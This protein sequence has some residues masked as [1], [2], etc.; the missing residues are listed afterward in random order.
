M[1]PRISRR[2]FLHLSALATAGGVLA[3]CGPKAPAPAPEV[4]AT[5]VP[6][7]EAPAT[8]ATAP[9]PAEEPPTA[10][11]SGFGEAP[12]LAE[13]VAA[14]ELPPVEDRLPLEPKLVNEFPPSELELEIGQY[15]GEIRFGTTDP[16]LD[17]EL[18]CACNE[19]LV[20]ISGII[21]QDVTPNVVKD[22]EVSDD[23]MQFTFY[24][25]EGLKWSDGEPVTTEDVRF[26]FEDVL[27][28][29]E[30]TSGLP[31][32]LRAANQPG[33]EPF[34]YEIID[35]FT[36]RMS[37]AKPYGGFLAQLAVAGWRGY[38]EIIKPAHYL[39]QFH[40]KHA[41]A[42]EL[43]ALVEQAGVDTWVQL[44]SMKD[45]TGV[46]GIY[47]TEAIGFPSLQP[48]L[49]A[50]ESQDRKAFLRNPYY[51]KVDAA[52]QQLPYIDRISS[53]IFSN[54]ESFSLAQIAGEIDCS[55]RFTS[56]TK[57]AL[58]KEN[59]EV[60]G[61][62]ARLVTDHTNGSLVHL[63]LTYDDPAWLQ[64][65]QDL[66]FRQA[67]NMAIDREEIIDAIYLGYG[68]LPTIVPSEFDPDKANQLLDE[69]GLDQRDNE[70]YRLGFDGKTFEIPFEISNSDANFAL[71]AELV[72]ENWGR[73]GLKTS[74]KVIEAN[75]WSQRNGA[76]ELQATVY[77]A[78]LALWFQ[79]NRGQD[80]SAPLWTLWWNTRGEEGE[81]PPEEFQA[82]LRA[83]GDR[84]TVPMEEAAS[85]IEQERRNVHDNIWFM[86]I[87]EN[88][89]EA[90]IT[91]AR[92]G[93]VPES[94]DLIGIVIDFSA[95][96][97]FVKD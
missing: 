20:N 12:M 15:G 11:E 21:H 60:G 1:R 57:M 32:W 80:V 38:Q 63:N 90:M 85:V 28:N 36:F 17:A 2:S 6:E 35:D 92:Y 95:E 16:T 40:P 45:V 93:N 37:F 73:I 94:E 51:F 31:A 46:A 19:P 91:N 5:D 62:K 96:Q 52:G 44:F 41:D 47:K 84:M 54:P 48:W 50:E 75:L 43:E 30:Y 26:C 39:K 59:E 78:P 29:Q 53:R 24:M 10:S 87:L 67:L 4:A 9:A 64:A 82:Y 79:P 74:M 23:Q 22:F 33:G 88:Y 49:L 68:A 76:N 18:F 66:R 27:M 83:I 13:K 70:G 14:G 69:I 89:K 77:F 55:Y 65:V 72:V 34:A 56:L 3:A 81:E 58:Y 7:E 86:P 61:F 25:R 71:I 97:F 42:A 8:E